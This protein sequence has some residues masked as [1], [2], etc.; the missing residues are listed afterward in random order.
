MGNRF[1][2]TATLSQL[3]AGSRE[4]KTKAVTMYVLLFGA[5]IGVF[6]AS[7]IASLRIYRWNR[8]D[9]FEV[10]TGPAV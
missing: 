1:Y 8:Y 4:V 5:M 10:N 3:F 6:A 2:V 7:R 9:E